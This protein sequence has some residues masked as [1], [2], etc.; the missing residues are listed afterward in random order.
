M[1]NA[2]GH[3]RAVAERHPGA[4]VGNIMSPAVDAV[5]ILTPLTLRN[6]GIACVC[7]CAV[8]LLLIPRSALSLPT[9]PT[10]IGCAGCAACRGPSSS[11]SPS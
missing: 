9:P 10:S 6:L 5:D 1:S 8:A 11:A 4:F 2:F 3:L 7:M